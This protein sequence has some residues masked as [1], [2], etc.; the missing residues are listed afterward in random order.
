MSKFYAIV[1]TI[2]KE[3]FLVGASAILA[4]I[5]TVTFFFSF[6]YIHLYIKYGRNIIERNKFTEMTLK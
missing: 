2:C 3:R 4:V 1:S 6:I 5:F